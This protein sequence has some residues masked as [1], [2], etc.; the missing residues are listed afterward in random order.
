MDQAQEI[1]NVK[2]IEEAMDDEIQPYK[3]SHEDFL[4][5]IKKDERFYIQFGFF[6]PEVEVNYMRMLHRFLENHDILYIKDMIITILRELITNA[7][8]ANTKRLYFKLQ[9]LDIKDT[10]EYR[11]GMESFKSDVY[12]R[13]SDIFVKLQKTKLAIRV[14]FETINDNIRI[15]VINNTS[16]LKEELTKIRSRLKKAYSYNDISE[17]FDDVIDDSEGTGLGLIM[18]MMVFKSAG[19]PNDSFKIK[20]SNGF[21]SCIL[22]IPMQKDRYHSNVRIAEELIKEVENIPSFP[23]SIQD[24]QQLCADPDTTIKQ[25]SNSIKRDPGLTTSILK[26]A[27]SAGYITLYKTKT[28]ED[29]VKLVGLKVIN[30][31]LV[32]SG[33]QK[34]LDSRYKKFENVWQDSN[35][36]AFY[37]YRM[38]IQTRKTKLNEFVYLATLLADIGQIVLLSVK[39]E[40]TK[41]IHDIAGSRILEN[42]NLLEEISLGVSH[43]TLGSLICQQ[44]KFNETLVKVIEYHERP[45]VA[46]EKYKSLVYL[47]YLAYAFVDIE[48]RKLRFEFIEEDVLEYYNLEEKDKFDLLHKVLKKA[49]EMQT[50]PNGQH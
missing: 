15:T 1:E 11:K 23:E 12:V 46:P 47:V 36:A 13:D 22:T 27:N 6:T 44:W 28:L 9:N 42:A 37:A 10:E 17:A 32:A 3:V 48:N 49:Y 16:I 31:L 33:V 25:I 14:I 38:S 26:L 19:F 39:P 43:S 30:T 50:A 41:R 21:T 20:S 18:A 35:R 45:Y 5:A 40:V 29:A 2:N 34:I 7:V 4:E 8:K 24:I